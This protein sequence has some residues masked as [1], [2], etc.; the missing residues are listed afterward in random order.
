M[1]PE[2]VILPAHVALV[3]GSNWRTI[4]NRLTDGFND[5]FDGAFDDDLTYG[6]IKTSF[7]PACQAFRPVPET[8]L[9]WEHLSICAKDAL[10]DAG[11]AGPNNPTRVC[12]GVSKADNTGVREKQCEKLTI[13]MMNFLVKRFT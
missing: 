8:R 3:P 1:V 2:M 6:P 11:A 9:R 5:A 13:P 4:F 10:P 12:S 7:L